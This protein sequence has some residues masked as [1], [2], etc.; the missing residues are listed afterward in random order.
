MK[1]NQKR[2]SYQEIVTKFKLE[3]WNGITQEKGNVLMN[4]ES[5][6]LRKTIKTKIAN[7]ERIENENDRAE[8][9]ESERFQFSRENATENILQGRYH[10][11]SNT[12]LGNMASMDEREKSLWNCSID[13]KMWYYKWGSCPTNGVVTTIYTTLGLVL[14]EAKLYL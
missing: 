8:K 10:I 12:M 6:D 4:E 13:S 1:L 9:N 7:Q 5:E 3:L 2:E 11:S 14:L